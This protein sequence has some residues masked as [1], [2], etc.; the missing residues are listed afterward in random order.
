LITKSEKKKPAGLFRKEKA[1][2]KGKKAISGETDAGAEAQL[3]TL[4]KRRENHLVK[5]EGGWM[6]QRGQR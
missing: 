5:T 4:K 6:R 1:Q 2:L 3:V